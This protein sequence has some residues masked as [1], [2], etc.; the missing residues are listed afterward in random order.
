MLTGA[1]PVVTANQT[2]CVECRILFT[3]ILGLSKFHDSWCKRG[4]PL[5]EFTAVG[6]GEGGFY[7]MRITTA[8]KNEMNFLWLTPR[9]CQT[10][11]RVRKIAVNISGAADNPT[12]AAP[13]LF[14]PR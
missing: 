14:F 5:Q 6:R 3:A 9:R 7:A 10:V 13:F 12:A 11:I 1:L 2:K 4:S 8:K